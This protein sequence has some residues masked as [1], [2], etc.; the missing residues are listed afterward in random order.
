MMID[1]L[2]YDSNDHSDDMV[3]V[4]TINVE[5]NVCVRHFYSFD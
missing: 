3:M 4:K 1:I 5:D 2:D